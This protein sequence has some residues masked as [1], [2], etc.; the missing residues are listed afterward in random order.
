MEVWVETSETTDS[1]SVT[2]R[3]FLEHAQAH[4]A[5]GLSVSKVPCVAYSHSA[6]TLVMAYFTKESDRIAGS[7]TRPSALVHKRKHLHDA[8]RTL[9]SARLVVR[10]HRGSGFTQRQGPRKYF[11][12]VRERSAGILMDRPSAITLVRLVMPSRQ[13]AVLCASAAS[14]MQY[15]AQAV[16]MRMLRA[17]H[18]LTASS[19]M[20]DSLCYS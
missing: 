11:E 5:T 3:C 18:H 8:S 10:L 9:L 7:H 6:Y 16:D 13:V 2:F 12:P 4:L 17:H 20:E 15:I 19:V 1:Y 14:T